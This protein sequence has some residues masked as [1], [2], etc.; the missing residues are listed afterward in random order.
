MKKIIALAVPLLVLVGVVMILATL[1]RRRTPDWQTTL[2]DYISQS[3]LDGESVRVQAVVEASKPWNF[4]ASM[5]K[6]VR[7]SWTWQ[8]AQL[9]FPPKKLQCVLVERER[10]PAAGAS[11]E[12]Q[13]QVL[14]VAY[15]SDG[16]WR[17]GWLVHE[18]PQEPF[19]AQ[20]VTD[21]DAIGCDLDLK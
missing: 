20:L 13:R 9:P 7:S 4:T 11:E 10:S 18:G 16:L 21:L 14:Y 19:T 15:H 8:I 1:E 6:A 17:M 5:G 3:A 12:A 2:N